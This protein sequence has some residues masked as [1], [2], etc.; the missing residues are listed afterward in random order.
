MSN[1]E[2]ILDII[3]KNKDDFIKIREYLHEYPELSNQE[4][5]GV[6]KLKTL[7]FKKV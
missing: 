6:M 3:N 1:K 7:I 2:K 5:V 4:I